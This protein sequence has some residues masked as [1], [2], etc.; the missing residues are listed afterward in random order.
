MYKKGVGN[1]GLPSRPAVCMSVCLS[2]VPSALL[3]SP[4][5]PRLHA[6]REVRNEWKTRTN[7]ACKT[8]RVASA[9]RLVPKRN[10]VCTAPEVPA[11]HGRSRS[12]SLRNCPNF[13][14]TEP[15]LWRYLGDEQ[16]NKT[17]CAQIRYQHIIRF[18]PPD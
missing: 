18:I 5:S 14:A 11:S 4:P 7:I 16:E 10:N 17:L 15:S 12:S 2:S 13:P 6:A 3:V 8:R 1:L 9:G